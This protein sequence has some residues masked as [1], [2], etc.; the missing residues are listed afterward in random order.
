MTSI[1]SWFKITATTSRKRLKKDPPSYRSC[2]SSWRAP[3]HPQRTRDLAWHLP[4][5]IWQLINSCAFT[6]AIEV[7]GRLLM[8]IGTLFPILYKESRMRLIVCLLV[9]LG[10]DGAALAYTVKSWG[11]GRSRRVT[12]GMGE[13]SESFGDEKDFVVEYDRVDS[14]ARHDAP[15]LEGINQNSGR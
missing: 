2:G 6:T 3:Q 15:P 8:R 14:S 12:I 7:D 10:L 13:N 1:L 5:K 9:M 11:Q 4:P